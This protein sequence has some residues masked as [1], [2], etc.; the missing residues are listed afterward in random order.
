MNIVRTLS[1][2]NSTQIQLNQCK[3]FV[4][5]CVLFYFQ[6]KTPVKCINRRGSNNSLITPFPQRLNKDLIKHYVLNH[7]LSDIDATF[8]SWICSFIDSLDLENYSMSFYK[9]DIISKYNLR[10]VDFGIPETIFPLA[11]IVNYLLYN[12][13]SNILSASVK[14]VG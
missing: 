13:K 14:K 8:I 3:K 9:N 4:C 7:N 1:S 12:S 5:L 2:K 6:G 10:I 11:E